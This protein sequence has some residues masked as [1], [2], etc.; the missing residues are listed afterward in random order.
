MAVEDLI[1]IVMI[2]LIFLGL[3]HQP[4]HASMMRS[5]RAAHDAPPARYIQRA[6]LSNPLTDY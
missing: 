1:Q 4:R 2:A 5:H 3:D 6:L